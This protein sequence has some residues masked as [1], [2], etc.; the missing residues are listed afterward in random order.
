MF[1]WLT[2]RDFLFG[3]LKGT[4]RRRRK[5]M[6]AEGQKPLTTRWSETDAI[7]NISNQNGVDFGTLLISNFVTNKSKK[8]VYE[9]SF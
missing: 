6:I 8:R 2:G 7:L 4:E 1:G 9:R 3:G 5:A